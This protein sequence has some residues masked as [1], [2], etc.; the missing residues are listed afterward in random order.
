MILHSFRK[1]EKEKWNKHL[2]IPKS[3]TK[4]PDTH[5]IRRNKILTP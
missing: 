5:T 2:P 1:L 4:E 3:S